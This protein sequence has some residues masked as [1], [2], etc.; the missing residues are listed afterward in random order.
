MPV[1]RPVEATDEELCAGAC[2][3][4]DLLVLGARD[5]GGG[6]AERALLTEGAAARQIGGGAI[7]AC[8]GVDLDV[9]VPPKLFLVLCCLPCNSFSASTA[10]WNN[11]LIVV[12]S[13]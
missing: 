1:V 7:L 3:L 6:A 4:V 5:G 12:K 10:S 9:D 13:L 11:W 2:T 8:P